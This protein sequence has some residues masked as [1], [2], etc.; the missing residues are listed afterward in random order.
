MK[1]Q[2]MIDIILRKEKEL[3]NEWRE[4]L[5]VFGQHDKSTQ[6]AAIRWSAVSYLVDQLKIEE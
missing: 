1:K 6:D 5:E 4:M 2:E 3:Y